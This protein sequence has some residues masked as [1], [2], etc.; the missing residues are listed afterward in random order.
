MDRKITE[1]LN[2]SGSEDLDSNVLD[3]DT[4]KSDTWLHLL[5]TLFGKLF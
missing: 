3:Y 5:A 4:V 1:D 2:I